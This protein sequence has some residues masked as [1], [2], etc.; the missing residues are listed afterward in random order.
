MARTVVEIIEI[1]KELLSNSELS[2]I[3]NG[4]IYTM[5]ERPDYSICEDVIINHKSGSGERIQEG[6]A[7]ILIYTLDKLSTTG[8]IQ[9]SARLETLVPIANK[10]IENINSYATSCRLTLKSPVEII[11]ESEIGQHY[12]SLNINY[13]LINQ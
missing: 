11:E 10:W 2:Q 13:K 12:I 4:K 3:V 6:V 9:D 7:E 5:G 1:I 8:Y